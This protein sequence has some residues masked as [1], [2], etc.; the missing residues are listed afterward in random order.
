M[1]ADQALLLIMT[2]PAVTLGVDEAVRAERPIR[3]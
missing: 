2:W 1:L 3:R